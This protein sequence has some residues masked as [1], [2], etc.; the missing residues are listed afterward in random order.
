MQTLSEE[1]YR[2]ARNYCYTETSYCR[3]KDRTYYHSDIVRATRRVAND[4]LNDAVIQRQV[5]WCHFRGGRTV[6]PTL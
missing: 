6:S 1:S 3:E 5:L 4:K 2:R